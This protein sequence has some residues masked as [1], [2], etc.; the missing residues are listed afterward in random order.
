ME[1]E[2]TIGLEVHAQILTSSK[3]FCGCSAEYASAAPNTHVCPV[4]LGLPGAL[5]VINRHAI[6]LAVLTGQ[7]LNCRIQH[8][9]IISRKN[10]FYPDL[11]S[12]YQRTQYDD[13]I[14]VAG[15]IEIEG[16]HGPKRIG[17]TRVHIE[18]DTAKSIH[19]PDRS[20]LVNFNRAGVPLMEIVSEPDISSPAEAKI[21]FQKLREML[22]WI[23][24]N[25]GNME[26]GALRCDANISVRPKGQVKYGSKVEI[27][28]M[29]SFRSV[30]R[31][32]IY[33]VDRQIKELEAGNAI[34]Q[35]TRGWNDADGRTVL[36]R[37]K[38]SSEDYRYFPEPDIPPL[39]LSDEWIE[40]RR[41]ELPELP[42]ARRERFVSQ[43][44]ISAADAE[45]LTIERAVSE[46]YETAV[47]AAPNSA[48]RDVANWITGELFRLLNETGESLGDI[49][50][51]MKPEYVGQVQ[52]LLD[53]GSI[54]RTSA[55]EVFELSF[56]SG[57]APGEVVA[58]R[59]LAQISA[60]DA[61][62]TMAREAI[63]NNPKA[64]GE[65]RS[66]KASAIQFLVGQ[67]MKLSKGQANPQAV[68]AALEAELAE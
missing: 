53:K 57:K 18:E 22:M 20:T 46:Y 24:V 39:V 50:G 62:T 54:T 68:R 19:Q 15:W 9:N 30:E 59:G 48:A 27:K 43:Y 61:L 55:K 67:V 7:A 12:S 66:G 32:L 5:P 65:Y 28:N 56:R 58:E 16:D 51:R 4:C 3:M 47:A 14:C 45:T 41:A 6:E 13:P 40:A 31:A 36:Q 8:E 38:E 37:V 17:L 26:E 25:T 52:D 10:Y 29:N 21:F 44:G 49:L 34:P 1:Y 35:S 63:A 11:P 64:V 60:G 2:V 23:G 42:D 33:E